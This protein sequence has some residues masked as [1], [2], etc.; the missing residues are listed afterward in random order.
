MIDTARRNAVPAVLPAVAVDAEYVI[1]RLEEAG[2]TLLAL[3]NSGYSTRLRTTRLDIVRSAIE[4]YG[5][6]SARKEPGR[7]SPAMPDATRVTRMDEA[8]AWIPLIPRDRYVLRRIVGA[9]CLVSPTTERHLFAWRRL[10]ALLG[11]DHKAIQRWHAQGIDMIVAAVNAAIPRPDSRG[12]EITR[13]RSSAPRVS[14][15]PSSRPITRA[16]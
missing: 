3:P 5:W 7:L 14:H 15:H 8:L 11:A 4:G 6:D 12:P 9:R 13:R 10:A 2:R 16:V 1:Y